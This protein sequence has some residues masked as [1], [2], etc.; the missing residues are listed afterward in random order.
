[1]RRNS[2]GPYLELARLLGLTFCDHI[3]SSW[4]YCSRIVTHP[5]VLIFRG[6][7]LRTRVWICT[8]WGLVSSCDGTPCDSLRAAPGGI[9]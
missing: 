4:H 6:S 3:N 2:L 8:I 5:F 9:G 7:G 1:M